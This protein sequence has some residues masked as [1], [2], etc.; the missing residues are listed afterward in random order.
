MPNFETAT[1][2]D[3]KRE[4]NKKFSSEVA[5]LMVNGH[6]LEEDKT[7]RWKQYN[8][9]YLLSSI[10]YLPYNNSVLIFE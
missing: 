2:G 10:E 3:L 6:V 5:L 8:L 7:I 9:F 4:I 1:I